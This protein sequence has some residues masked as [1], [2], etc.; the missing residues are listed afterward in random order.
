MSDY[1]DYAL[2]GDVD[3]LYDKY[4]LETESVVITGNMLN[5]IYEENE[6]DSIHSFGEAPEPEI[7]R[8]LKPAAKFLARDHDRAVDRSNDNNTT[9]TFQLH[10]SSLINQ[11]KTSEVFPTYLTKLWIS[12]LEAIDVNDADQGLEILD[13][14]YRQFTNVCF[15]YS[16]QDNEYP[17]HNHKNEIFFTERS[18]VKH[19]CSWV[20]YIL[21]SPKTLTSF[22]KRDQ[23]LPR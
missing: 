12:A 2:T 13:E 21:K 11:L 19:E 14:V 3:S 6:Y 10:V 20:A 22:N 1:D 4:D 17:F 16:S 18:T 23:V 5:G 9:E 7:D 8:G 15:C